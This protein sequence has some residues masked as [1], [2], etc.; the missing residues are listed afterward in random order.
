MRIIKIYLMKNIL[1]TFILLFIFFLVA[2]KKKPDN[3]IPERKELTFVNN[4][5]AGKIISEPEEIIID[6]KNGKKQLIDDFIESVSYVKLETTNYN[7]IGKISQILI[8]DSLL[9]IVDK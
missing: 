8:T 9:I 6:L 4:P 2:C 3:N 5:F 7:L 1:F